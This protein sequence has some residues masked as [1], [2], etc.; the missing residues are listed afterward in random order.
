[1]KHIWAPW[2][3]KYIS[4]KIAGDDDSCFLCVGDDCSCDEEDL[5]LHRGEHCYVIMNTYPYNNGHLMISTYRHVTDVEDFTPEE[6]NEMMEL[7]QKSVRALKNA[8]D[9]QGFN[10]GMNLGR[11]AGAGEEHVHMHVVPRWRGDTNFMPV[12]GET[13]LLSEYL[14]ETYRRIMKGFENTA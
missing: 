8:F 6:M 2:R 10:I 14:E 11:I 9:P 3:M 4:K 1:M 12:L 7:A 5:V 13:K